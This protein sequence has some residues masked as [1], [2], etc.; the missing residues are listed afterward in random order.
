MEVEDCSEI[1]GSSASRELMPRVS[2]SLD[3]D[4]N[5]RLYGAYLIEI[6]TVY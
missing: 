4:E 1:S 5:L 3:G 2:V 6:L